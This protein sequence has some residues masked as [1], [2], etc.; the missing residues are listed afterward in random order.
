MMKNIAI[1]EFNNCHHETIFTWIDFFIF[2]QW[3]LIV[4]I[5]EDCNGWLKY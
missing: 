5:S 3:N 1:I 4:F 2:K